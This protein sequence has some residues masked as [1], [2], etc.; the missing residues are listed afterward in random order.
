ML[1]FAFA[2]AAEAA[3]LNVLGPVVAKE[4]LGGASVWGLVLAATGVGLVLGGLLALRLRPERP[5]LVGVSAITL[6][7]PPLVLLAIE[8]PVAGDRGVG[9]LA[10]IGVELFSV[11]WDTSLQTHVP[12]EVLSRVSR[13]GMRSARSS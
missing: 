10:G 7:F 13:P 1:G 8:A 4:S 2:N 12:N 6:L 9:A 11:F 3:G 5:L